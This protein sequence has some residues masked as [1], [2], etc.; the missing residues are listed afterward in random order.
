MSR[1][2][3]Y[4]ASG[5]E[6][7]NKAVDSAMSLRTHNPDLEVVLFTDEDI[8]VGVFDQ[9]V[10]IDNSVDVPGDSILGERHMCFD[11]NLY[12]DADTRVCDD[13][14]GIFELLEHSDVIAAHNSGRAWCNE[15]IY[16]DQGW[17]IPDTFPEYNTGVIGFKNSSNVKTLFLKW[18]SYYS[19]LGHEHNQPSFRKALYD[20][21]VSL[22]TL[23]PEY[24]FMVFT[25]G[26]VSGDVKI[27]HQGP[28]NKDL[29][30]CEGLI[31]EIGGKKVTTLEEFPIRV[32]GENEEGI[33]NNL[34]D[35]QTT[36]KTKI[37]DDG[38]WPLIK[39]IRN[40]R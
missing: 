35:L 2:A 39:S 33:F 8:D 6:Y 28:C 19:H 9:V 37:K 31:N 32:V 23:P 27:I 38:F 1:G 4:I 22:H 12:I 7:L 34:H 21:D 26:F 40:D 30:H 16:N 25:L 20:C 13:I 3:I 10:S 5:D 17:N 18:Q 11:K 14:S 29:E 15:Q 24:N 36:I